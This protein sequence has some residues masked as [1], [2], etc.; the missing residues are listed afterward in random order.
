VPWARL[1]R[2]VGTSANQ[3]V[4][5][6]WLQVIKAVLGA[7]L[8]NVPLPGIYEVKCRGRFKVRITQVGGKADE[9]I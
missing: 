5:I 3:H 1:S 8:G 7:R 9:K 2:Y 4:V 6:G